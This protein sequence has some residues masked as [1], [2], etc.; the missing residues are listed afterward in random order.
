[1]AAL[2]ASANPDPLIG[3]AERYGRIR[4]CVLALATRTRSGRGASSPSNS[5]ATPAATPFSQLSRLSWIISLSPFHCRRAMA[6]AIGPAVVANSRERGRENEDLRW[7]RRR[8]RRPH[9]GFKPARAS[10]RHPTGTRR[11]KAARSERSGD[12]ARSPWGRAQGQAPHLMPVGPSATC[13]P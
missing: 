13:M 10:D 6:S 5:G 2:A 12:K 8:R 1:V 4:R 3:A 7:R 9:A 11:Q